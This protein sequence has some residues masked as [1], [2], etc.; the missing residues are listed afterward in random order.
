MRHDR[1]RAALAGA[2]FLLAAMLVG[3]AQLGAAASPFDRLNHIVVIYQENWSFDSLYGRFPG[4]NGLD[5]AAATMRQVDKE[6]APYAT[7]PQPIDTTA[8]P[9]G[10]DPR[11][12]AN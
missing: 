2:P 12:P 1:V 7:L 4:A 8:S 11:F 10:P 6:G 5:N 3:Q 9:V